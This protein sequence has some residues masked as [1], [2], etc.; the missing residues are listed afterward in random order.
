MPEA[1][2]WE[3]RSHIQRVFEHGLSHVE[4]QF[5]TKDGRVLDV[6]IHATGQRDRVTDR[7]VATRAYVR[8]MTE[9]N[10][11]QQT[12]IAKER[13]SA[14]GGMA[15]TLAHEIRNPLAGLSGALQVMERA[16]A[17]Q[18][19]E[20][21][22]YAELQGQIRRLN[23]LVEDLLQYGRPITLRSQRTA[24]GD[25]VT[26][27]FDLLRE[28]REFKDVALD[29]RGSARETPVMIDP[30][31]L[32]Q[33]FLNLFLNSAQ[34]I[35]GNGTIRVGV[36]REGDGILLTVAD[37]GPGIPAEAAGRLFTPFFTTKPQGTGLGLS[38]CR[39]IIEAHGGRIDVKLDGTP[40]AEFRIFLPLEAA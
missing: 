11:L 1:R 5:I 19:R 18:K 20:T 33:A 12:L 9:R 28:G 17:V 24:L 31:V 32:Q 10:K 37:T 14:I 3:V 30:S 36:D 15:V 4:T 8:D 29:L 34:A 23:R 26:R 6:E 25:L 22:I 2:R 27:T 13:L 21:G 16:A 40:G 7:I 39:R 38:I 35:G